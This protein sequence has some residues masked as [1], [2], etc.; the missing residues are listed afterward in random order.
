[1]QSMRDFL[2]WY[3][4]GSIETLQPVIASCDHSPVSAF[5]PETTMQ[6]GMQTIGKCAS[7]NPGMLP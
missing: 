7:L 1:M 2:L 4:M 3:C 6:H 5:V